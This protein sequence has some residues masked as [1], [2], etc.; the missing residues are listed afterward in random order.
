MVEYA[1]GVDELA[2]RGQPSGYIEWDSVLRY[3]PEVI[4]L[5]PCGFTT[6][7]TAEQ[8]RYFFQQPSTE[9]LRAVRNHRVYATD[10]HNYFSRSGPRLF[11]AIKTLAQVIHPE[12]FTESLDSKIASRVEAIRAES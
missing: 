7:K 6:S 5:M 12:L 10:G 3:D 1:G 4:I 2:E 11:D 8:A 9:R